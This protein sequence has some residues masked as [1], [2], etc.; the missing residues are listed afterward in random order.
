[1]SDDIIES[2]NLFNQ[3]LES[4][5]THNFMSGKISVYAHPCITSEGRTNEDSAAF[6]TLPFKGWGVLM[7]ADGMGGHAGGADA[8]K[9]AI[10]TVTKD[11][12]KVKEKGEVLGAM[13]SAIDN[14]HNKVKEKLSG[15]GTTLVVALIMDKLVRIFHVG[16]SVGVVQGSR[17]A[18]KYQTTEHSVAG[19]AM[20]SEVMDEVEAQNHPHKNLIFNAVGIDQYH[21]EVSHPVELSDKDLIML[22]SDGLTANITDK[23]MFNEMIS[24]KFEDRLNSMVEKAKGQMLDPDAPFHNP[25][26]LTVLL[27][28]V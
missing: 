6:M 23:D 28:Q 11:L 12:K 2:L 9:L 27:F 14:A 19:Y 26:D 4:V 5:Q 10:E 1:M 16:D 21:I 8:S 13:I 24:G 7:V 15:A 20:K 3:K 22:A 17:G 25:D 18:Y